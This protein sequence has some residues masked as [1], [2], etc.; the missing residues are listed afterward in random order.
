M[1]QSLKISLSLEHERACIVHER[2]HAPV[3]PSGGLQLTAYDP[4]IKEFTLLDLVPELQCFV[5]GHVTLL[6]R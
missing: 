2:D 5:Y 1:A 6:A 3:M 4:A